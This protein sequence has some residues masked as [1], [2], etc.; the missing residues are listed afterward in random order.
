[1][2]VVFLLE[3]FACKIRVLLL[4]LITFYSYTAFS[5]KG[6]F[7]IKLSY[8]IMGSSSQLKKGMIQSGYTGQPAGG[9]FIFGPPR[10]YPYGEKYPSV[11]LEYGKYVNEKRSFSLLVGLEEPGEAGG[12]SNATSSYFRVSHKGFLVNPKLNFHA[13]TAS[14]G[15]GPGLLIFQYNQTRRPDKNTVY[16]K[17]LPGL[18]LSTDLFSNS[19]KNFKFTVFGALNLY[20]GFKTKALASNDTGGLEY[21]PVKVNPSNLQL[22]FAF[23]FS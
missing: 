11:Y 14:F 23:R 10:D 13:A 12:Y 22:G 5:Q 16:S 7:N 18:C 9:W 17:L 2:S 20:P 8:S 6:Y 19:P 1:M 3:R 21:K 4:L 15:V